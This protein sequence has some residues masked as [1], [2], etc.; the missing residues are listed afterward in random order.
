MTTITLQVPDA[1]ANLP[2]KE[3]E[4]LLQVGLWQA[5][6]AKREELKREIAETNEEIK[7]FSTRY[8]VS[9]TR[10]EAELLPKL[11]SWQAHEDYNDW[12]F[13]Q[14]V[15]EEKKSLL[16]NLPSLGLT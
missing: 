15:L 1:L 16:A 10:F 13:L 12:F 2:S 11:K 4:S 9:F 7:G 5:I 8:G 3:R 6:A 14:S